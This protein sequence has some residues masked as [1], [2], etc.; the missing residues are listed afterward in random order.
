[1]PD[2]HCEILS[3]AEPWLR[4]RPKQGKYG[5]TESAKAY[6]AFQ[7]YFQTPADR[8][9]LR[10]TAL[11]V[12]RSESLVERWSSRFSWVLRTE[13]WDRR[14][15]RISAAAREQKRQAEQRKW[16]SRIDET[17]ETG[18]KG[19]RALFGA[20]LQSLQLPASNR[21]LAGATRALQTGQEMSLQSARLGVQ[22][23]SDGAPEDE[24]EYTLR[25]KNAPRGNEE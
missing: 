19:G 24:Y 3:V 5:A 8:R 12:G 10:Q 25:E 6:A 20:G 21:S 18:Y 9:S 7:L 2:I 1:M 15:A 4:L 11:E 23:N 22:R 13:A 16:E 17:L 14:Q